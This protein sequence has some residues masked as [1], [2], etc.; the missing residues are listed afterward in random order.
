MEKLWKLTGTMLRIGCLGF[1]GGSA[2]I[3][4]LEKETVEEKKLVTKEEFDADV[5]VASVTPGALP[6]EIASGI[7]YTVA[8]YPG[9]IAGA[10]GM[11]LPGALFTIILLVLF[12]GGNGQILR[13]IEYLSVGIYMYIL[14]LL[15]RYI[16]NVIRESK[17][18]GSCGMVLFVMG[19]VFLT[20]CI[21]PTG[22]MSW[23]IFL[24]ALC[25][26]VVLMRSFKMEKEKKKN[27]PDKVL[28]KILIWLLVLCFCLL[29][30]AFARYN[31][32]PYIGKGLLSAYL[33]FGGGDAYLTVAEGIFVK[34][35][36]LSAELFYGSLVVIVNVLPGSILCKML[37]G[38]GYL[39]GFEIG[40][41][42]IGIA[43]ALAG[44]GISLF[45]SCTAFAM[46]KAM[47]KKLENRGGA[48]RI[49]G[50]IRPVIAGLLLGICVSLVRTNIET[51]MR[52]GLSLPYIIL[53]SALFY[54]GISW[55][56]KRGWIRTGHLV[57]L[58]G[59]ISIIICSIF[60]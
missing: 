17:V 12:W 18:A 41:T 49:V 35:G 59:I 43:F 7:G 1:G 15:V 60:F 9:M 53:L 22:E 50:W 24:P 40:G 2:L 26:I 38:I 37:S 51:G 46:G 16:G 5:L 8:G 44:F 14:Y 21:A 36:M 19:I 45:G 33:S 29:P 3:P 23:L 20:D 57:L 27:Q 13:Q 42:G 52:Y 6:V 28:G 56:E 30:V 58:V 54:A 10:A 48:E 25:V 4:L 31:F 34:S 39:V 32:I 55:V 11:A 47:Y